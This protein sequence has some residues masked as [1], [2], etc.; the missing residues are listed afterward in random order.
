VSRWPSISQSSGL[1][2]KT[3]KIKQSAA[4]LSLGSVSHARKPAGRQFL[5]TLMTIVYDDFCEFGHR[6]FVDQ[7]E[8]RTVAAI[9][10]GLV[11]YQHV[12]FALL[13]RGER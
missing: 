7:V 12:N 9:P 4:P 1:R 11:I 10:G 6:M 3:A 8:S 13:C 5:W 2:H